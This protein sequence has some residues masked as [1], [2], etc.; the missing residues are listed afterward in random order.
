MSLHIVQT[1]GLCVLCLF[2]SIRYKYVAKTTAWAKEL[3][4]CQTSSSLSTTVFRWNGTENLQNHYFEQRNKYCFKTILNPLM[5]GI[6]R[7][8]RMCVW[9]LRLREIRLNVGL[10]IFKLSFWSYKGWIDLC[11]IAYGGFV[12]FVNGFRRNRLLYL[13]Y[14]NIGFTKQI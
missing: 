2:I 10:T 12:V 9:R 3:L 5:H 14:L 1:A 8:G 13:L 11:Q 7:N 6:T 4:K